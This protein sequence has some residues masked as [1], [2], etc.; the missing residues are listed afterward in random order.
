MGNKNT[1]E[2]KKA[3]NVEAAKIV[4]ACRNHIQSNIH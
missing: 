1:K 2:C 4:F 3:E